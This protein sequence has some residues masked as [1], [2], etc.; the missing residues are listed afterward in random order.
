MPAILIS[1]ANRGLGLGLAKGYAK[2]DGN[3]VILAVRTPSSCPDIETGKGSKVIVV[4]L[5]AGVAEDAKKAVEEVRK[6][7][8]DKLDVVC[9]RAAS[10]PLH[11]MDIRRAE[12]ND[13]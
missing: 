9:L 6:Q 11:S 12:F 3:T 8:V 7:G 13:V 4:K 2:R 5:D 1:G 10:Y